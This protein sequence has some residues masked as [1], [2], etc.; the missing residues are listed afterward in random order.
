MMGTLWGKCV[1]QDDFTEVLDSRID[2]QKGSWQ[3]LLFSQCYG[4]D[5]G[6]DKPNQNEQHTLY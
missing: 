1:Q 3:Q 4:F 6:K 2:C 5:W